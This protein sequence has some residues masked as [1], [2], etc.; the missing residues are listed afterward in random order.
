M[1]HDQLD[2]IVRAGT[3]ASTLANILISYYPKCDRLSHECA[4]HTPPVKT[5]MP[6][7]TNFISVV[8][9][10]PAVL[11]PKLF[12]HLVITIILIPVHAKSS[13]LSFFIIVKLS[14][15]LV[16]TSQCLVWQFDVH[17]FDDSFLEMGIP[18]WN[19][20]RKQDV[21][22]WWQTQ[23]Q[24]ECFCS[25]RR[26]WFDTKI[27]NTLCTCSRCKPCNG[28]KI[29]ETNATS[30]PSSNQVFTKGFFGF[31]RHFGRVWIRFHNCSVNQ[32]SFG[33][34]V[35]QPSV[36]S[37][38]LC[39]GASKESL[40]RVECIPGSCDDTTSTRSGQFSTL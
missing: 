40:A 14:V 19:P 21:V 6:S 30:C 12:D 9:Y 34:F 7:E 3:I 23:C 8:T 2:S 4:F 1:I 16:M 31:W 37:S 13:C 29:Y 35:L 10:R 18:Q 38:L 26:A 28:A 36:C 20:S 33:A 27:F 22:H 11:H 32:T 24:S 39:R 15:C 5:P 17:S 25:I